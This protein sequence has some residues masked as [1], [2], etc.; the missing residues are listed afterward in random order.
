MNWIIL[1]YTC[2][3]ATGGFTAAAYEVVAKKMALPVGTMFQSNGLMTIIGGIVA[4][5]AV[6]MSAFINPWWSLFMVFILSWLF[7]QLLVFTFKM[8]AQ[9]LSL[10]LIVIGSILLIIELF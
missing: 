9:L 10:V 8:H 2:L 3:I 5:V 6:I 4:I 1:F 7:C